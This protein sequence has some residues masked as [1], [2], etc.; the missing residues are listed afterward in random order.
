MLHRRRDWF[1][2]N[3]GPKRV[4]R[5]L[6]LGIEKLLLRRVLLVHRAELEAEG[7]G[8]VLRTRYPHDRRGGVALQCLGG[9]D[10]VFVELLFQ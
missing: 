8:L 5:E 1:G 3:S 9:D 6:T 2:V 4:R 7:L 10:G